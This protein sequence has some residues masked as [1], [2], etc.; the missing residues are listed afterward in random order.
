MFESKQEILARSQVMPNKIVGIYFLIKDNE[1]VYV[2]QSVDVLPR[3]S[4]HRAKESK[5]FS[6]YSFIEC[7]KEHLSM[8]EA[9]YIYL[10]IPLYNLMMPN[11]PYYKSLTQ[12]KKETRLSK[13]I[14]KLW[15]K[16]CKIQDRAGYY[17]IWDFA[18]LDSFKTWMKNVY[19][20][21]TKALQCFTS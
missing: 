21:T 17:R 14:L 7:N 12:L 1:I 8:L 3:I 18:G 15:I 5:V 20:Y 2:G 13:N 4:F 10:F 19:S 9:H 11:N 6:H 16:H